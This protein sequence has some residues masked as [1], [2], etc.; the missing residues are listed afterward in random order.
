M[1]LNLEEAAGPA[2]LYIHVP[3][4]EKKCPYC[5]FYSIT[6][7]TLRKSY[8]RALDL[9]PFNPHVHFN[10]ADCLMARD[11]ADRENRRRAIAHFRKAVELNPSDAGARARLEEFD[12]NNGPP[13]RGGTR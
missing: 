6:D 2:G 7:T 3:F 4:C 9:D 13:V 10:Y 1:A 11:P 5:D 12:T 8:L